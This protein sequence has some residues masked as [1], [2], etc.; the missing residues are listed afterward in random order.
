MS[1]NNPGGLDRMNELAKTLLEDENYYQFPNLRPKDAA[2]LIL[3][4]RSGAVPKVLLGK[5]HHGHKFMPGKFVFPGG[6]LEPADRRM[7]VART[8]D[9]HAEAR[10]MQ[11]VRRPSPAHARALALAAI[12]ETG[13][14]TGLLL[15]TRS[16]DAGGAAVDAWAAFAQARV[17]PDLGAIHFIGRAI[18]PPRRPKR[19]DARFFTMDASAIAHRLD[20]VIGPDA[21]LVELVWMPLAEAKALDMATVTGVMLEELD[22]RIAAGLRHDLPVP[23]YRMD[24]RHFVR[25]LL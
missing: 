12:R 17:L 23:F 1:A 5:R 18:T 13:E 3:L 7:A 14:E 24:H 11:R 20:G 15:G 22:A 9:P 25:E 2:T 10:L 6:G 21:E 4:D 16:D 19:F 8:L